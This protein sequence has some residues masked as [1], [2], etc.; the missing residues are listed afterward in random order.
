MHIFKGLCNYVTNTCTS[1]QQKRLN[2][3]ARRQTNKISLRGC[4]TK[5]FY[6]KWASFS[7]QGRFWSFW[8]SSCLHGLQDWWEARENIRKCEQHKQGPLI[9]KRNRESR[10][11]ATVTLTYHLKLQRRG[12]LSSLPLISRPT[13]YHGWWHLQITVVTLSIRGMRAESVWERERERERER[14]I[15]HYC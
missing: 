8:I 7:E 3:H 10:G 12:A 1:K 4:E 15:F 6:L 11:L 9:P 2:F 14:A 5:M 13:Y